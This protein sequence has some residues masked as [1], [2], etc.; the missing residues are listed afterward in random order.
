M[1]EV[2]QK[3]KLDTTTT[4]TGCTTYQSHV[5]AIEVKVTDKK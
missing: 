2:K 5:R 3:K 1:S 4:V